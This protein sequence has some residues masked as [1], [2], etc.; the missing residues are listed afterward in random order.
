[1]KSYTV[2]CSLTCSITDHTE[3]KCNV[4]SCSEWGRTLWWPPNCRSLGT[5]V[6]LG[7]CFGSA[8]KECHIGSCAACVLWSLLLMQWLGLSQCVSRRENGLPIA[9]RSDESVAVPTCFE[10]ISLI[11]MY[12]Q[13]GSFGELSSLMGNDSELLC[14]NGGQN[15]SVCHLRMLYWPVMVCHTNLRYTLIALSHSNLSWENKEK[16]KIEIERKQE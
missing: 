7:F 8:A 3:K 13:P 15:S 11:L 9:V 16:K 6:T 10:C 4:F 2:A 5:L 14:R 1:M 12:D